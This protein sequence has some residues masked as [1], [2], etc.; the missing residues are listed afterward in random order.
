MNDRNVVRWGVLGTARIAAKVGPAISRANG[1]ELAAIASRSRDRA[2]GW[3]DE[4]GAAGVYGS[5]QELID[6]PD[7]HA[8]YIPLPPSLHREWT[9]RAAEHGKHVL[10]E[11]PLAASTA[12]AEDMAAACREHD[13]QLM[14]GVMWYHHPRANQMLDIVHGTQLGSLRR[15]TSAYSFN[16]DR[17]PQNDFRFK[18]EFGGGALLDLGWYCVGAALRVFQQLPVRVWATARLRD[19]VDMNLTGIMWFDNDC[20]A[21]FNCGFDTVVRRWVEVAGT[22]A[23]LICDDFARPWFDDKAR[24]WIHDPSGTSI[25]HHCEA[26]IQEDCMVERTS[27]LILDGRTDPYWPQLAVDTQRVCEALDRS[28]RTDRAIEPAS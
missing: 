6:D 28:A 15:L 5:Y 11:K 24:F 25:V 17:I 18:R 7:I 22:S 1:A 8:V 26:P 12:E 10:C 16:A 20:V 2:A 13:V 21:S 27:R 3:A 4:H 9:I 19:D 14:D 23:S